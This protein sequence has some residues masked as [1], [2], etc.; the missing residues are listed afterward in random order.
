MAKKKIRLVGVPLDL[1]GGRRG[2]DMG[3]SALRIAG[4]SSR[5]QQ[6]GYDVDDEGNIDVPELETKT[7]GNPKAKYLTEISVACRKLYKIVR[8]SVRD[9]SVPLV[10]G[11]DHSLAVGSIGAVAD[12]LAAQGRQ[13]GVLWIDAH[14]DMNTP[15][16]SETG[17]VH[18]MPLAAI[19]GLG[20]DELV[21]IGNR[22]PIV[23]ADHVALVGVRTLDIAERRQVR[24][25]GLRVYTMRQ[26]DEQGIASVMR[27][28][29]TKF[30]DVTDLH[31]SFDMDSLDP[32]LAPGTGTP[33][34]GG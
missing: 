11:G 31:V 34:F 26:I 32:T 21:R 8:A 4:L 19:I 3:P 9:G 6:L 5:L 28:I 1:G 18:G 30:T 25:S 15:E 12:A 2:V 13:L 14:G 27:D 17:N 10:L 7:P 22:V 20:A 16:T 33:A 24:S 23:P 29:L